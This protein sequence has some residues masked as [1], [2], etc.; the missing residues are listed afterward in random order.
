MVAESL[1]T[2]WSNKR[3]AARLEVHT[4]VEHALPIS[5]VV[6]NNSAHGMCLVCERLLLGE[7]ASYDVFRRSLGWATGGRFS[8]RDIPSSSRI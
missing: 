4:G 5:Y 6:F 2:S 8:T 3:A 7:N 1:P